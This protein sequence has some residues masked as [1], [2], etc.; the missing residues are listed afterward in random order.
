[1]WKLTA[2]EEDHNKPPSIKGWI[3]TSGSKIPGIPTRWVESSESENDSSSSKVSDGWEGGSPVDVPGA[4]DVLVGWSGCNRWKSVMMLGAR[5]WPRTKAHPSGPFCSTR[6]WRPFPW[7]QT[8]PS[9]E[10]HHLAD[11]VDGH[12]GALSVGRGGVQVW[13]TMR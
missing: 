6:Y 2:C 10:P 4:A 12:Q 9:G 13:Q 1:M 8:V 3:L 5:M 7:Q 11:L